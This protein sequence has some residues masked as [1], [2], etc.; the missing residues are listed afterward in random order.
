MELWI[1]VIILLVLVFG[2]FAASMLGLITHP[3]ISDMAHSIRWKA[4][5]MFLGF[6]AVIGFGFGLAWAY[7]LF[8]GSSG[9][10]LGFSTLVAAGMFLFHKDSPLAAPLNLLRVV[11]LNE[12]AE[13]DVID[14]YSEHGLPVH[15]EM[16][17]ES[18]SLKGIVCLDRL[19]HAMTLPH[20]KILHS[21]ILNRTPDDYFGRTSK[22]VIS[23]AVETGR[24][25][26]CFKRSL[27]AVGLD[28]LYGL[29]AQGEQE[30]L[31]EATCEPLENGDPRSGY[32]TWAIT[33]WH[34][35]HDENGKPT[36]YWDSYLKHLSLLGQL[37]SDLD[38]AKI[39]V[40]FEGHRTVQP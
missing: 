28:Y 29:T 26:P 37:K 7:G 24:I 3:L 14:L 32:S 10:V 5:T 34:N 17:V 30:V 27:A 18:F 11:H 6:F 9:N 13:G 12:F 1:K 35:K 25:L 36:G 21:Y 39:H 16:Q 38:I 31:E 2:F 15:T 33:T 40:G 4:A 20:S 23:R 19:K 22:V 8:D